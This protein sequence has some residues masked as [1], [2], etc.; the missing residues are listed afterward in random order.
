MTVDFSPINSNKRL[1]FIDP[2]EYIIN[3]GT[4]NSLINCLYMF[5][6]CYFTVT[7]KNLS[8]KVIDIS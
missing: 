5:S 7:F 1:K 4:P 3:I 2:R 6:Y 8:E